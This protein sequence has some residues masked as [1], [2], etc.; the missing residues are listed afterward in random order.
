MTLPSSVIALFLLLEL[1]SLGGVRF[2][3][4]LFTEG[5]IRRFRWPRGPATS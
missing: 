3:V 5:R 4:H 2:V 1:A